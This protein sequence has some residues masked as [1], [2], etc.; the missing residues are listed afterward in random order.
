MSREAEPKEQE[1]RADVSSRD[2]PIP[3]LL[4]R[5]VPKSGK[6]KAVTSMRPNDLP[7]RPRSP[8]Q[9]SNSLPPLGSRL[10]PLLPREA[11]LPVFPQSWKKIIF[12][13]WEV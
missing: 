2:V 7:P 12:F 11:S 1:A 8:N 6:Q 9:I 10:L 13:S 4:K 3:A 5:Y